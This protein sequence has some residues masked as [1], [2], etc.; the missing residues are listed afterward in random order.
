[1]IVDIN[2]QSSASPVLLGCFVV[3]L[4]IPLRVRVLVGV[5]GTVGP[6]LGALSEQPRKDEEDGEDDEPVL[7]L[8]VEGS[9][10]VLSLGIQEL[11]RGDPLLIL[12]LERLLRLIEI[13]GC[14]LE[15]LPAPEEELL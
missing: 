15:G 13:A 12:E 8:L 6:A 5:E 11:G 7:N 14:V 1:M 2:E 9:D 4:V 10:H 3:L